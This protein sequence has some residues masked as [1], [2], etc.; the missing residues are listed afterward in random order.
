MPDR[1]QHAPDLAV[2]PLFEGD[3]LAGVAHTF[4]ILTSG[5]PDRFFNVTIGASVALDSFSE[6]I[7]LASIGGGLTCK[8]KLFCWNDQPATLCFMTDITRRKQAEE[9]YNRVLESR[10]EGFMLLDSDRIITEVNTALSNIS[11]YGRNDFIGYPVD[12]FYDANSFEF[13]SASPNHFSFEALFRASDGRGGGPSRRWV[14]R[15]SA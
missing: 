1:Q 3:L 9:K 11:G 14:T 6:D 13:Y 15:L 8:V 2:L 4:A 12:R 10:F 5:T 7:F